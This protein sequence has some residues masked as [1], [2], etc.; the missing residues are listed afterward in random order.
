MTL[1]QQI[2]QISEFQQ[3]R[4]KDWHR[5]E[6]VLTETGLL[7]V[8]EAQHLQNFMLWHEEDKARDPEASDTIIAGV[9]RRI[10]SLNQKRND[11]IEQLDE[12]ILQALASENIRPNPDSA[13]NSETPGSMI[14][15]CSIM[16]LKIYHMDEQAR[17][18]DVDPDHQQQSR[19]KAHV[20]TVQREDLFTCLLNL[21]AEIRSG[22]RHFRLYRQYKMYNDPTL[23]PQIYK[24]KTR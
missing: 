14:D 20:L 17:R 13:L 1:S 8:V 18:K 7:G 21:M 19:E 10:D 15:R 16:A 2:E 3:A 12:T 6:P 11:L 24:P 22:T 23:N 4:V 9:K 5:Q